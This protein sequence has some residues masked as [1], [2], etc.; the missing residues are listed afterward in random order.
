LTG[1]T[2]QYGYKY[3]QIATKMGI[4]KVRCWKVK[5]AG[6]VEN[7]D[8]PQVSLGIHV[9]GACWPAPHPYDKMTLKSALAKRVLCSLPPVDRI[10]LREFRDFV[11]SFCYKKFKPLQPDA[12][13][14]FRSWLDKTSYPDWRKRQLEQ[15]QD[16][17]Q[18]RMHQK[19]L[20][21][22]SFIKRERYKKF[23]PARTINSRSDAFK[24]W[25]GPLFKLIESEVYKLDCFVKHIPV[26]KRMA[27]IR[28][29][30]KDRLAGYVET[31]HSRFEAHFTPAILRACELQV[32]RYF[33]RLLPNRA[34]Y[35][36]WITKAL[37]GVNI[38]G[39]ESLRA[40]V[41][42]TRMSGDMC[43]SLGNGITNYLLM[44]FY[45]H[46]HQCVL[47]MVVE[48]DDGLASL[49]KEGRPHVPVADFFTRLG[50]EIKMVIHDDLESAGF[51]QMYCSE[52][53]NV[54]VD[55]VKRILTVG[56]SFSNDRFAGPRVR[57]GLLRAKGLSLLVESPN[58]PVVRNLALWILRVTRF[59]KA[60]FEDSTW[61][62]EKREAL[63]Q[64]VEPEECART[65]I[66]EMKPITY[67]DR[68][69]VETIFRVPVS[70]QCQIEKWFNS[71][72][73]VRPIPLKLVGDLVEADWLMSWSYV[74]RSR[75][76]PRDKD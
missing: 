66:S 37:S 27:Y 68:V 32:Y 9:E 44:A 74:A 49:R 46:K 38:L 73:T 39:F 19:Y 33:I 11:R 2:V 21:C 25:S 8:I 50:F 62:R 52:S 47:K 3:G 4:D 41:R 17:C 6:A 53:G 48:G 55:P 40:K 34:E 12:D 26:S 31:D 14:G 59:V 20:K 30:V 67:L 5:D 18:G 29:I 1:F 51:C 35:D 36:Y 72:C 23:K 54:L 63:F 60:R 42:G 10:L 24:G 16:K 65:L 71:Q 61:E 7:R 58:C 13:V 64:G 56:W 76:I 28:D 43:T 69:A 22:K 57:A 70:Q 15:A 75:N 45:A